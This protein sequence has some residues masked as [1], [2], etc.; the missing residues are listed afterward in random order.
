MTFEP[1]LPT[2]SDQY[3]PQ[4]DQS[5]LSPQPLPP[6]SRLGEFQVNRLLATTDSGYTYSSNNGS[7]LVQE[8]F[9]KQLAVRDSDG[10][11]LLLWDESVN[12]DYEQSLKDFLL[13]ARVLSQIDHP[14]RVAHYGEQG[15]S[16]YYAVKFRPLASM[17]D[18]LKPQKPLPE[19][20][21]KSMLYSAL[22]YLDAVHTAGLLHLEISPDNIF[23]SENEQLMICGFN[24][25]RFHYP[26]P[27]E[28]A[29]VDYRS[30]ELSTARGQIGCWTDFYALGALLYEAATRT[31]PITSSERIDTLDNGLPDPYVP[32]VEAGHGYFSGQFL[33]TV[34]WLL[35]LRT[36]ERPQNTEVILRRLDP[37]A[38][39]S[40]EDDEELT[41]SLFIGTPASDDLDTPTSIT[42]PGRP[43]PSQVPSTGT[44][45]DPSKADSIE[46]TDRDRERK[47]NSQPAEPK[48]HRGASAIALAALKSTSRRENRAP[49]PTIF[50]ATKP[51]HAN[52]TTTF[53][54]QETDG[55]FLSAPELVPEMDSPV[56]AGDPGSLA[57]SLESLDIDPSSSIP[58]GVTT[59]LES[60]GNILLENESRTTQA[61]PP[62]FDNRSSRQGLRAFGWII[63][64][65]AILVL[66]YWFLQP[67]RSTVSP[68]AEP[69]RIEIIGSGGARNTAAGKD[70]STKPEG[71]DG[72]PSSVVNAATELSRATDQERARK[73]RELTRL[74]TLTDPHL[75]A[76]RK[77]LEAGQLLEPAGNNAY[78]EYVEVLSLD[79]DNPEA[80]RGIQ[81][82]VAQAISTV[83]RSV[84]KGDLASARENLATLA[85]IEQASEPV[86]EVQ[87]QIEQIEQQ[88]L[89]QEQERARAEQAVKAARLEQ[90]RER[91]QKIEQLLAKA[92]N[93]FDN[94]QRVEPPGDNALTLYRA[95]LDLN[96]DNQ[97]ARNGIKSISEHY[98]RQA[99]RE[100]AAGQLGVA[101]QSLRIA[102]AIEPGNQTVFKLQ[103]Q[104]E[105]RQHL[106][107]EERRLQ[108]EAAARKA[109]ADRLAAEQDLLN[110]QSGMA[111]YYDGAYREAYRFLRP[112]AERGYPRAQVRVARMLH[113]ARG[114]KRDEDEALRF[115]ALALS[116]VQL[117]ASEGKAWAQSDLGDYFVDG[118]V[119][120]S[121]YKNAAYWYR[122]AADQG[123]AP[124]QTN[125]GWLYMNGHGVNPDREVAIRWFKR[126]AKQ[127]NSAALDNLR[128]LGEPQPD[129]G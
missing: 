6:G 8:F 67:E 77:H 96:P 76:A 101:G 86:T 29:L 122:R 28:S 24:T 20:A 60:A 103:Q 14:G 98:L 35:S 38:R 46:P 90:E 83:Q 95:A 82:I 71:D 105:R 107:A 5:R 66:A 44:E 110:L 48:T 112:L 36:I 92:S 37:D 91:R 49:Q 22:T 31:A 100:L 57:T 23:I 9:P 59:E 39:V 94:N 62:R 2:T 15:D 25:D 34:D 47:E 108:V 12:E 102:A 51:K 11:S 56:P 111:A 99:Q 117:A 119:I 124:A 84:N 113:S 75:A 30:P 43:E 33:E 41:D 126:A 69:A 125:L 65:V 27:D 3:P 81:D 74:A 45:N 4:G 78:A 123:Y 53:E 10:V 116:P 80:V 88:R 64:A 104:L 32:A 40:S 127:G 17:R 118:Y 52:L 1:R 114:T 55:E 97:R 73:Y 18:L 13:L 63:T 72:Q 115:F 106:A 79:P 129:S 120:D 87:R 26:P 85:M 128:V 42:E 121:D 89:A 68:S 61:L 21:L 19:D 54:R 93:A 70:R 50:S 7:H 58:V 109:D 16:A